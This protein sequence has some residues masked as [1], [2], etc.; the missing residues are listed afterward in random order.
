M[1]ERV[2][3]ATAKLRGYAHAGVPY[4]EI[5]TINEQE[6]GWKPDKTTI[7]KKLKAMGVEPRYGNRADL[8]P[9]SIKPEHIESRFRYMLEAESRRREGKE[10]R[11]ADRKAVETLR[12]LLVPKSGTTS[13]VIGYHPDLGFYLADRTDA[14]Q[15][16]IRMPVEVEHVEA[17]AAPFVDFEFADDS[18]LVAQA[19][20]AGLRPERLENLGRDHAADLLRKRYAR[21]SA[22]DHAREARRARG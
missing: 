15:D 13:L 14:D 4:A 12:G 16:I 11:A 19:F 9:W 20:E 8:V 1:S 18:Q 17:A 5:A 6:T 3:M 22:A 7:S 10:L 2:W 21:A